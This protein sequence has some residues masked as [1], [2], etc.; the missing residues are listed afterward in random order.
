MTAERCPCQFQPMVW[1]LTGYLIK[2]E[3]GEKVQ[4]KNS[5]VVSQ[6]KGCAGNF[7]Y[8][9]SKNP[10]YYSE[11]KDVPESVIAQQAEKEKASEVA[12][13]KTDYD[14]AM[15]DLQNINATLAEIK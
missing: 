8:I 3:V 7:D 15:R 4:V 12:K 13:I 14:D 6:G 5:K 11:F 9:D 1:Q 2:S 10:E